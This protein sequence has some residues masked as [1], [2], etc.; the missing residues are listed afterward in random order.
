MGHIAWNFEDISGK[1]YGKLLVIKPH[2]KSKSGNVI[3]ECLCDCGN[4][5]YKTKASLK[6]RKQ[7]CRTCGNSGIVR[8]QVHGDSRTKLYKIWVGMKTRCLNPHF[9]KYHLYGGRGIKV[10]DEWL[11]YENFKQWAYANGFDPNKTKVEQSLD[12]ID[13]N[14]NY[15]PSNCRWADIKTQNYNRRLNYGKQ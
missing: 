8:N 12:R 5:T 6:T 15:E 11:N 3:Y 1:R 13:C 10:C 4:T 9:R 14:G 7:M 2:S